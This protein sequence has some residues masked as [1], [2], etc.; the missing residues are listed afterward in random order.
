M[1]LWEP[2]IYQ[3]IG[4]A[5]NNTFNSIF[6]C[7]IVNY[8]LDLILSDSFIHKLFYAKEFIIHMTIKFTSDCF[9]V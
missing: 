8:S 6:N 4:F 3:L 9:L 7:V 1:F 5:A 2:K